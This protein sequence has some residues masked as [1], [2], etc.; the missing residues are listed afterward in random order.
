MRA[1]KGLSTALLV[2]LV[3]VALVQVGAAVARFNRAGLIDDVI[4]N[5]ISVDE[6]DL[7]DADDGVAAFSGLHVLGV[8][9]TG[10]VFIIWQFR[11]A[12]NAEALGARGGLGAG[13]AIGGWFVPVGN[14]VLPTVQIFQSS[15][16]SAV[17]DRQ[18]GVAP[19]GA[20]IVVVWG[21]AWALAIVMLAAGGALAPDTDDE[22][23][24]TVNS[25]EDLEDVA[26]SDRTAGMAHVVMI[27]VAVLAI[28]MVRGLSNKQT[29]AWSA[30]A[31]G[32]PA[33]GPPPPQ[34]PG[35][36]GAPAP[37]PPPAPPPASPPPLPPPPGEPP[38]P[39]T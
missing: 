30:V 32:P 5:P 13:W 37:P 11:H 14:L 19:K 7:F 34:P 21:L 9:A 31:A 36:W 4:E 16:A 20:P 27:G 1:L 8:L 24:F 23:N 29:D 12:K 17:S 33:G 28:V 10:I 38:P 2:M 26:S 6:Q 39:P 25:L 22:G 3:V 15:K 35:T 18:Q